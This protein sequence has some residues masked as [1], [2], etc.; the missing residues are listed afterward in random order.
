MSKI[1]VDGTGIGEVRQEFEL[2]VTGPRGA[3]QADPPR[4][5]RRHGHPATAHGCVSCTLR[6][7]LPFVLRI[8]ATA[9]CVHRI[10]LHL[11]SAMEP[12]TVCWALAHMVI[13]GDPMTNVVTALDAARW[14]ADVTGEQRL[15]QRR[16]T[17]G[18]EDGRT[19]A[20]LAVGHQM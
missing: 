19:V 4:L 9:A 17:D 12:V 7:K 11:D 3:D 1:T 14:L 6:E 15:P 10:V 13:D 18:L 20:Q 2:L 16:P 8:L 5:R